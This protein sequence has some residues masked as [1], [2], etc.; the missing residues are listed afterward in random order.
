[1]V[2]VILAIIVEINR[3]KRNFY[4]LFKVIENIFTGEGFVH[5]GPIGANNY[6][7]AWGQKKKI[8]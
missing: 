1:M 7:L 6:I 8:Y 5:Y 2:E 3:Q 4:Y